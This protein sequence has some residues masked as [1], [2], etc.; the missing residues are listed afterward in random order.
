MKSTIQYTLRALAMVLFLG[1]ISIQSSQAQI[2]TTDICAGDTL[3]LTLAGYTGSIQWKYSQTAAAG[4][5]IN[6]PGGG[7]GDSVLFVP[8]TNGWIYAEV[9]DGDCDPFSSDTFEVVLNLP[10]T[11]DA[12][13]DQS[14]CQLDSVSIGGN[15]AGSGGTGPLTYNWFPSLGLS[16]NVPN[17][18][19]APLVSTT[20]VLTVTD[21]VG[22][23]DED[24]VTLTV[25]D[26]PVV[27][28]GAGSTINCGDSVVLQGTA[29]GNGPF[30]Y[31]WTPAFTLNDSSIATPTATPGGPTTYTLMVTDANGCSSSD[32]VT[33]NTTGGGPG[34]SDTIMYTGQIVNYTVPASCN[35]VITIEVWGAEG[36]FGTSSN[37]QP[38]LGAYQKG[39][40][41]LAQGTQLKILVGQRPPAGNGGGGGTFVTD[42]ANAPIIIAGGGGGGS[43]T[44]DDAINKQGQAGQ[45]GGTGAA[46]GGTGG[47]MGNGGNVGTSG[48]QSGAGGGLLTSGTNGWTN[49]TAGIAFILGGAG[50]TTGSAPGGF[51]GGGCGS[52]WVVG[53]GG[54]G[55][56]VGGSGGNS[57]A[58]VGGGGGSFN[59]GTN[60]TSTAGLRQ[61]DGMVIITY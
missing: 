27:D 6:L 15:P 50:G 14:L 35:G 3:E 17:P 61:G 49:N 56:S 2:S 1:G 13:P 29:T 9:T 43:V 11:A 24:T 26:I 44:T 28:A 40:F 59:S 33:I 45:T 12:G 36:G 16:G 55:Y 30:M 37:I 46:G 20:Y 18:M 39:D 52:G 19:A 57:S 34:G 10:P 38:G 54:G 31:A 23:T 48:F 7:V 58:G 53:G 5:Y 32:T 8:S 51:G 4:P 47:T 42:T 25:N 60:T 41:A 21:S 22:C